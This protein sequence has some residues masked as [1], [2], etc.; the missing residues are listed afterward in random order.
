V[1]EDTGGEWLSG[2]DG[3]NVGDEFGLDEFAALVGLGLERQ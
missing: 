1:E 3:G 2:N